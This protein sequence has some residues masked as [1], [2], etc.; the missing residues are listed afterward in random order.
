MMDPSED[1]IASELYSYIHKRNL[2]VHKVIVDIGASDGYDISNSYF[3]IETLG[4]TGF[5]V[6]PQPQL[7][8]VLYNLHK[9][10]N[11]F[12]ESVAIGDT[13]GIFTLTCHPNDDRKSR[14]SELVNMGASLTDRG[15]KTK[16]EVEVITFK[17]F[18]YLMGPMEID[19]LSIDT[20]GH[21]VDVIRSMLETDNRPS[22]II[23]EVW[24]REPHIEN[25][26]I[27]L[28][29]DAGYKEIIKK[30]S[31]IVYEFRPNSL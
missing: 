11:V 28:L 10:N 7:K 26:K 27:K 8:S 9:N 16:W 2:P 15:G 5:L 3:F 21:D 20:E 23:T 19:V 13:P 6:E 4:W 22:F 18:L 1:G 29:Q 17:Q 31:N 25:E 14:N 24:D 12:V 30:S